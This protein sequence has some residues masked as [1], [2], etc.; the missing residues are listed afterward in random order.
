MRV[1]LADDNKERGDA[2]SVRLR[3][4]GFTDIA[5]L[6]PGESLVD[7]V[8]AR[9]PDVVIMDMSQPDRESLDAFRK[10]NRG[11]PRP[12][13]LFVD[14]DDPHF[15]EAAIEAGVSSYNLVGRAVPDVKPIV[16]TALAIFRRYRRLTDN[17]AAAETKLGERATIQRAKAHLMR[18]QGLSEPAAHRWLRRT[19]MNRG[20]RM[21]DI[22]AELLAK[23]E[24]KVN[25]G[26]A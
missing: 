19:A 7:A 2:V 6:A 14:H 21:V 20:R 12:I 16:Q 13:V 24:D 1:L 3:E 10:L 17:L 15:M 4:A 18:E 9:S 5:R 23:A 8:Q 11:A 22:A 25:P 26:A